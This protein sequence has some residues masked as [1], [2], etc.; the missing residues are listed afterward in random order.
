MKRVVFLFVTFSLCINYGGRGQAPSVVWG[1]VTEASSG[2]PIPFANVVFAGTTIGTTTDFEGYYKLVTTEKVDSIQFSYIGFVPKSKAIQPGTEQNINIQM[3]EDLVSLPELVFNAGENPAFRILRNVVDHKEVNDKRRLSAYEYEAYT[4]IEMDIDNISEKF[5][6]RKI[7]ERV[8]TV[9]DSIEQIAGEDG[10]PVLPVF[11]SEAI[12]NYYYKSNPRMAHENVLNTKVTGIGVT[13]GTLTSQVIGASFQQ[14]NFYQNWLNIVGKDFVSPIADSWKINYEYDLVDSLD[15]G[16]YYCYRLDFFPKRAQDLAFRGSMWIHKDTWALRQIDVTVGKEAN[17]NFV[18]KIKIQQE[19]V[20]TVGEAWLPSKTRVVIDVSEL[21]SQSAGF[22]AKFYAS[23]KD[24][25]VN[26]PKP[27]KF[28]ENPI[29]MAENVNE[30][31][32]DKEFWAELRHD[33]LSPTEVNVYEMIDTL[34]K[35]PVI[36]TYTDI[37]QTGY[38]GYYKIGKIDLGSYTYFFGKNNVEG[39]RLGIGGRTNIAFSK[40]WELSA[41][42]AYGFRDEEWKYRFH[43]RR[44]LS[45]APWTEVMFMHQKEIDQIWLLNDDIDNTNVFY[46]FARFGRLIEPFERQKNYASFFRVLGRGFSQRVSYKQETL[47]PLFDFLYYK[48]PRAES[49]T[50]HS[51]INVG[52][53][54]FDTRY[55]RDEIFV[56]ND[57]QRLSMGTIRWPAINL[58]YTLGLDAL[59]GDF[60]YHKLG[61]SI[62]KRQKMGIFGTGYLTLSGGY[63]F[64]ELPYPLLKVHIGNETPFYFGFAYNVM[65]YFEFVTDRHV[66]FRWNQSFEGFLVNSLPA[67]RK[68][69]WRLVGTFNVLY[70]DVSQRNYDLI[71]TSFDAEGNEIIPFYSLGR[72]PYIE[73]GYGVEN[74]F[75]FFRV[76]FIH[77]LTYTNR[78]GVNNFGIKFSYRFSL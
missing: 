11:I 51:N 18:E 1:K 54:I 53:I 32:S 58:R 60:T 13:D 12:S 42:G 76:D 46:T 63:T 48:D 33:T 5:K 40:K 24:I 72:L 61:L 16:G 22:L 17:V 56:I 73:A 23:N 28:Y 67:F 39:V 4:K 52:E 43:V 41:N 65:D 55:A 77:R 10:K 26:Q 2:S 29:T 30:G 37:I 49:P 8:T 59:G 57:N 38:T 9:L 74:I 47:N 15:L 6:N 7:V 20:P 19:L 35:I 78:P 50:L 14:Y 36:K 45:R 71:P 69:K 27:D 68:L 34:T 3:D 25:V 21:S 31:A 62:Q 75:R 66:A 64:N 44:I 70:G